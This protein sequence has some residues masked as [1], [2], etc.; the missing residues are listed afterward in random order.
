[1]AP[2]SRHIAP[3]KQTEEHKLSHDLTVVIPAAGPGRRMKS[4]G[5]R[6]LIK[7]RDLPL[8]QYQIKII[9]SVYPQADIIVVTG[10][11]SAKLC[12]LIP[13]GIRVVENLM[14]EE[15]GS[16]QS[17]LLGIQASIT[18]NVL[19]V[20]GDLVFNEQALKVGNSKDRSS[21]LIDT[22][23]QFGYDEVGATVNKTNVIN[24]SYGLK[25]KWGKVAFLN[26][27]TISHIREFLSDDT[28]RKTYLFEALN[29][30]IENNDKI[31][32]VKP[33]RVK[34]AEIDS[35]KDIKFAQEKF[36]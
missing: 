2:H 32:A 33:T 5:S 26:Q 27:K 14:Y 12:R 13:K 29:F 20:Y 17:V 31:Y 30:A 3:A 15:T 11:E 19:V 23:E 4:Y 28:K 10:F 21:V 7:I 24:F 9:Q 6:S 18:E 1:M 8:I 16:A 22:K 35:S 36:N 34:V 25:E